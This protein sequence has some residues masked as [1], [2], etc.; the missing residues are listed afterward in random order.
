M[1]AAIQMQQHPLQKLSELTLVV[2]A[3]FPVPLHQTGFLQH[4][5]PPA[6][7]QI[8]R[9]PECYRTLHTL[10]TA[11]ACHLDGVVRL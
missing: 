7:D 11:S 1:L 4:Y 8:E 2:R 10:L 5:L 9:M 6:A 3:P